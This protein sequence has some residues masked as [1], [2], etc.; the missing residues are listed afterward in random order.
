MRSQ[1]IFSGLDLSLGSFPQ[2]YERLS[3]FSQKGVKIHFVVY[4][5]LLLEHPEWWP[6]GAQNLLKSWIELVASVSDSLV[7]ISKAVAD[8]VDNWISQHSPEYRKQLVIKHFHLGADIEESLP[9]NGIPQEASRILKSIA[10]GIT[11]LMVGTIEPRKGY[12]QTLKA[13]DLLWSR[14]LKVNLVIV[15]KPGWMVDSLIRSIESHPQ[16]DTHLFWLKGISDEY[17]KEIYS[18]ATALIAASEGEG[19]GLPLIEAAQHELFIVA[20]DIPIF[21]EVASNYAFYFEGTQPEQLA[22]AIEIWT[23]LYNADKAPSSVEMPRLN[24]K[25]STQQLLDAILPQ[26]SPVNCQE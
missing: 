22:N 14:G 15:G 11:F 25:E 6:P 9:T 18:A 4:D 24:W 3:F 12:S 13:F 17:L 5:I 16:L 8:S 23:D 7:C 21:R 2:R 10:A 26:V 1:D 20:R 19:F